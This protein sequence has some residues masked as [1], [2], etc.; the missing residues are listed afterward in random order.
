MKWGILATGTIA[1]KFA[2]TLNQMEDTQVLAACASRTMDKAEAFR[3][4]YGIAR[5]YESYEAML[6]DPEVEAVYV[7]TPNNLHY[8][9]CRMCL[10]AGKHVLCE[11]PFTITREEGERLFALAEK[12]GLF[13][14]EA[15]WIRFLPALLK[16]RELIAS[17]VLGDVVWARSDYG[18]V[19]KG[20]RKDRKFDSS[21]AGG[22]LLDIGIYNLGFMRMVMG[23]APVEAFDSQ[24]HINEYGTDDFSTILL[25]YAG[26]KSACVT[27]SIGINMARAAVVYG[28]KGSIALDDFQHARKLHVYLGD[29]T[30]RTLEFPEEI[31]GFEYQIREVERCV[32]AGMTTSDVLKRDDTLEILEL[33]ERIR[34]SWG[35]RFSCESN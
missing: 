21:L 4:K 22:A 18:F 32:K 17:G 29:G 30:C 9:N 5:A 1:A 16:L 35:M 24:Y 11:K 20:A 31:N 19:A 26:G 33:M 10:N 15:F 28:T 7:A 14:M 25:R 34:A 3:E 27:T 2:E 23:D 12:K 6:Q 8:E 13:I